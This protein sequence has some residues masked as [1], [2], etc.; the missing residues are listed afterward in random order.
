MAPSVENIYLLKRH[1]LPSLTRLEGKGQALN[2][3][4]EGYTVGHQHGLVYLILSE[5]QD[6][7]S[8]AGVPENRRRLVDDED[9]KLP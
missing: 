3:R 6:L 4:T 2:L 1:D 7:H 8:V 5:S 9:L